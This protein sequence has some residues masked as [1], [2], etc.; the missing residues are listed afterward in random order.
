V[1][2]PVSI[3]HMELEMKQQKQFETYKELTVRIPPEVL[4]DFNDLSPMFSATD[5]E[6]AERAIAGFIRYF[7][8]SLY[9]QPAA[10]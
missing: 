2:E 6:F 10:D 9:T 7:L 3:N 8:K 1:T 5:E 4:A